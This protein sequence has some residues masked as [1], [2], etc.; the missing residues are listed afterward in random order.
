MIC[1]LGLISKKK[2][3]FKH[4]WLFPEYRLSMSNSFTNSWK[5][6]FHLICT[7]FFLNF[8]QAFDD[9]E[10]KEKPKED[11]FEFKKR[12][13]LDQEKSKMSLGELYE[14]EFLKQQQVMWMFILTV[15]FKS[16]L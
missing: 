7:F 16:K 4:T 11:P 9:V 6:I 2:V 10:R 8:F 1:R 14:Q 5:N 3:E 13:V 15:S 12:I